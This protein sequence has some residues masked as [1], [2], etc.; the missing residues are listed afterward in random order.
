MLGQVREVYNRL[1]QFRPG[2]LCR[3]L[4]G[5]AR[6]GLGKPGYASLGPVRPGLLRLGPF[7]QG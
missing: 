3:I 6:L 1:E 2:W 4:S 5:C 7:M